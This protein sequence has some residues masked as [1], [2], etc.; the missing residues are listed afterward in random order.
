MFAINSKHSVPPAI[1]AVLPLV[2]LQAKNKSMVA[3]KSRNARTNLRISIRST[4]V[5]FDPF[6][7]MFHLT[8]EHLANIISLLPDAMSLLKKFALKHF[9]ALKAFIVYFFPSYSHFGFTSSSSMYLSRY[10]LAFLTSSSP[11]LFVWRYKYLNALH[12]QNALT[13]STP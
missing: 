9:S 2:S 12:R 7:V 10:H 8:R 5:P 6:L 1:L 13:D 4:S 11:L 3:S